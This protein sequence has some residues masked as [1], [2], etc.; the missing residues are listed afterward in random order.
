MPLMC[1]LKAAGTKRA[2]I[3]TRKRVSAQKEA[4]ETMA[5]V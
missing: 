3:E 5:A 2:R 1:T 4:G